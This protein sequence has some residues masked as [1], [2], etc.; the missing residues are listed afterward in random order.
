MHQLAQPVG[1]CVRGIFTDAIIVE[2]PK[3][4]QFLSLEVG[5]VRNSKI[6]ESNMLILFLNI[7]ILLLSTNESIFTK[8]VN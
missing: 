5:G 6:S 7:L 4:K 3:N 8:T 1:G 2:N